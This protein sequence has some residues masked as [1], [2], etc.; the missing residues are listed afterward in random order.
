[1]E[2]SS[3]S[4]PFDSSI[5]GVLK[6]ASASDRVEGLDRGADDYVIKPFDLGELVARVNALLRRVHKK[7]LTPVL[8]VRGEGYRFQT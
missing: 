7:A 4:I 1:M 3:A 5:A 6:N 8:T 2:R